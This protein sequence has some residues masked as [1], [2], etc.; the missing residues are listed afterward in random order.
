[1]VVDRSR[2]LLETLI[3]REELYVAESSDDGDELAVS[4]QTRSWKRKEADEELVT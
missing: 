2:R 4:W 1:M 3:A